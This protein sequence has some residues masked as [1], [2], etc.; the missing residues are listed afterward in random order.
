MKNDKTRKLTVTYESQQRPPWSYYVQVP[1]IH[2]S[3]KWLLEA[4]FDVGD[5]IEVKVTAN[6]LTVRKIK[7]PSTVTRQLHNHTFSGQGN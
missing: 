4:G 6:C 5:K 2:L 1:R 7:R 3:G